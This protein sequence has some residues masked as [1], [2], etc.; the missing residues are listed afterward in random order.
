MFK[1]VAVYVAAFEEGAETQLFIYIAI[2]HQIIGQHVSTRS[3]TFSGQFI[4]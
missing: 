1:A 2:D 3:M 4:A